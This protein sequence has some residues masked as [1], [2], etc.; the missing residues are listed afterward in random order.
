MSAR[1]GKSWRSV[2]STGLNSSRKRP[3]IM[4]NFRTKMAVLAISFATTGALQADDLSVRNCTWCHGTS[5]Q[6]YYEAPRLAG[7]REDYLI[8]Q[9]HAFAAHERD[10][11]LSTKYMWNAA[12]HL[13]SLTL[14]NLAAYFSE[15]PSPRRTATARSPPRARLYLKTA[16]PTRTLPLVRRAM[17]PKRRAS[18]RF[19]ASVGS[20]TAI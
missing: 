8:N 9:L 1:S 11:F 15:L 12:A 16:F 4:K 5:A 19:R 10:E 6:G 18:A 20:L 17:A 13:D 2:A 14:R 7:Q 3:W